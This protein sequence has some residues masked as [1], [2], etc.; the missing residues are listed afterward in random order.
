MAHVKMVAGHTNKLADQS[1]PMVMIEYEAGTRAYRAYNPVN[2]KLVVTR[3]VLFKK[4]KSWNWSSVEPVQSISDEIF[5][6]VYIDSYADDQGAESHVATDTHLGR[7]HLQIMAMQRRDQERQ[8]RALGRDEVTLL[9]GAPHRALRLEAR[10]AAQPQQRMRA[11]ARQAG[12]TG[13]GVAAVAHVQV[14]RQD[15]LHQEAQLGQ[16]GRIAAAPV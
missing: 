5:T 4:E 7:M 11:E 6:V 12:Q 10:M 2:K 16:A 14:L 8:A 13:R 3:D 1:T 15:A 9:T